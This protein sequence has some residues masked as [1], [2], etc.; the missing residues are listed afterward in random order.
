M[1]A[2]PRN[3]RPVDYQEWKSITGGTNPLDFRLN[4]GRF[5]LALQASVWGTAI[6]QKYEAVV[7]NYIPV[8]SA[9]MAA[10]GYVV[11]DLPAGQ[12]RLAVNGVTTLG[13]SIA[14]IDAGR[15]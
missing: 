10:N 6:L 4:A 8:M 13:G 14:K 5:G 12:Y 9:A 1:S 3:D 7:D 15:V 2:A 11:I